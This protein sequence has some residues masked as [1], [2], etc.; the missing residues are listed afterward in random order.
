MY[1]ISSEDDGRPDPKTLLLAPR[2]SYSLHWSISFVPCAGS[3]L[4]LLSEA[5]A[6]LALGLGQRATRDVDVVALLEVG[7]LVSAVDLPPDLVT[8]RDRVARDFGVPPGWL[9]SGPAAM[10][11]LGLP[12]GF[13][14]RWETRRDELIAAARWSRRHDPSDGFLSALREALAYFGIFDADLEP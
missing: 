2:T 12:R 7:R 6:L 3:A 14:E 13:E 4:W 1:N 8:A 10:L 9:N 11:Q 5:A